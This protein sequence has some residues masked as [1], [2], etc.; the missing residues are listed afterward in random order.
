MKVVASVISSKSSNPYMRLA[1]IYTFERG[2]KSQ[3]L[4]LKNVIPA[5]R[6]SADKAE[7]ERIINAIKNNIARSYTVSDLGR[8]WF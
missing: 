1:Q 3:V 4:E 6:N 5:P 2:L 8:D 7:D